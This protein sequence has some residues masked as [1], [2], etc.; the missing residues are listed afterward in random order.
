MPTVCPSSR[1]E[2]D[3]NSLRPFRGTFRSLTYVGGRG[4]GNPLRGGRYSPSFEWAPNPVPLLVTAVG[5]YLRF[6]GPASL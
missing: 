2:R 5:S 4:D 1:L 6:E 3:P